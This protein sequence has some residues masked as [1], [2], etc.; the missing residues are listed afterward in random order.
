MDGCWL[1]HTII[2]NKEVNVQ[3][4][5]PINTLSIIL[6]LDPNHKNFWKS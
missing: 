3:R 5:Y 1:F 2:L 6:A 4:E